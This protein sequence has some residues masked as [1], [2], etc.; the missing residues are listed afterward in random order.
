MMQIL[1]VV[2][3]YA[4]TFAASH[5]SSVSAALPL[6][7]LRWNRHAQKQRDTEAQAAASNFSV[8]MTCHCCIAAQPPATASV[9]AST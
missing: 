1:S 8:S 3:C 9:V 4:T 2:D 6:K 7:C 5:N